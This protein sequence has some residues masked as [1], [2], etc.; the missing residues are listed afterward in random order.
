MK[1]LYIYEID[2]LNFNKQKMTYSL[3]KYE[4]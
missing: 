2:L 1:G 4:R 3:K